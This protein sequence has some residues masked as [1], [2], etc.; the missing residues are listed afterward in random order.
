MILSLKK[1]SSKGVMGW[2]YY[3]EA[4]T[5]TPGAT[6]GGGESTST[7][8]GGGGGGKEIPTPGKAFTQADVDRFLAEDR[9]K[10]QAKQ[11][12]LRKQL[13]Q[14][15][16]SERLTKEEKEA[17]ASQ[18]DEI[19]NQSLSKEQLLTRDLE[20]TKT[21]LQSTTDALTKQK[22]EW[23]QRYGLLLVTNDIRKAAVNNEA[24]RDEQVLDLLLPKAKVVEKKD[25]D[26]KGIGEFEVHIKFEDVDAKTKEPVVLELSP[27]AVVK[28]MKELPD[29]F[30]NLFK[31]G[32]QAGVG[33]TKTGS[34]TGEVDYSTLTP[35]EHRALRKQRKET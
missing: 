31:S 13:E 21:T 14:L 19:K 16:S 35:E 3:N 22:D 15:Q 18:I 8:P 5:T 2:S 24:Y 26:G 25:G 4:A 32:V 6:G 11:E 33:K 30:G 28:R 9:R 12:E 7:L 20:K 34:P 10:H 1:L 17:L 27:E 29:R 23:Q